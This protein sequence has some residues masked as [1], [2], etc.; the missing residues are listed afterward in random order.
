M[1][2]TSIIY[3]IGAI[4]VKTDSEVEQFIFIAPRCE[5]GYVAAG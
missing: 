2:N 3:Q 1:G 4:L 5:T